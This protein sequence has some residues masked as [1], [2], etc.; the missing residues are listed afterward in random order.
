MTNLIDAKE[1]TNL[2][3]TLNFRETGS[4]HFRI[5]FEF[6]GE[7]AGTTTTNMAAV[8]VAQDDCYD[9]VDNSERIYESREQ[10]QESLVSEILTANM[11][12]LV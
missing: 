9:D 5:T 3:E 1:M 8:D 12:E 10:A 4:G 11:I 2:I 6:E 7:E